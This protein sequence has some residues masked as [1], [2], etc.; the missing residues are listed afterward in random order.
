MK[1]VKKLIRTILNEGF[2]AACPG[3]K[4]SIIKI[5]PQPLFSSVEIYEVL[6]CIKLI[7]K[8]VMHTLI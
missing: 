3:C 4:Q 8:P 7:I 2:Y 1:R 6:L 5:A